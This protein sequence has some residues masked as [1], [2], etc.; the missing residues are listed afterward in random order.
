MRR[1]RRPLPLQLREEIL[2]IIEGEG[3]RPGDRLP[4]ETA[5]ADR[6]GVGRTTAREALKL[7]EQDGII[8][9]RHGSGR[10]VS[11]VATLERPITRLE[12][13]TEMMRA[14]GYSV[15]NRVISATA[16]PASTEEMATLGLPEGEVVIQLERVRLHGDEPL[17]YSVDVFQRSLIAGPLE[18]VDLSGSL[19]ES[20]E[21]SGTV[22][23]SA[24]AQ[25][26]AVRL[27]EAGQRAIGQQTSEPWVLLEHRNL[28]EDGST[29]IVSR[30]YYRGDRFTFNV[31][32]RRA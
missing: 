8:D 13:V 24:M 7:L 30:D 32:R 12:S 10:F 4:S 16:R 14:H 22:V 11:Q 27:P 5:I 29:V 17:I 15:T 25:L 2:A 9:V 31:F 28:A 26:H 6:F 19:L 21:A 20:L 1:G 23:T 3:L 18:D